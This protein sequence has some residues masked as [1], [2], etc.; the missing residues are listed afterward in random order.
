MKTMYPL[1]VDAVR[2]TPEAET[3]LLVIHAAATD[4]A[5]GISA[6]SK[7][8]DDRYRLEG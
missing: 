6:D 3:S 7:L 8:R 1:A 4:H 2:S 5:D